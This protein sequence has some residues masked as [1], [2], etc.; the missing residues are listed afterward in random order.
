MLDMLGRG[1]DTPLDDEY[2]IRIFWEEA[3]ENIKDCIPLEKELYTAMM[4]PTMM[5]P[6]P[7]PLIQAEFG[8]KRLEVVTPQSIVHRTQRVVPVLQNYRQ[9]LAILS[10]FSDVC[11][12]SQRRLFTNRKFLFICFLVT[13][14][15]THAQFLKHMP[16]FLNKIDFSWV[17]V[18]SFLIYNFEKGEAYFGTTSSY[19]MQ[20]QSNFSMRAA[21]IEKIEDKPR[22]C[23]CKQGCPQC[24]AITILV[25]NNQIIT[26]WDKNRAYYTEKITEN[27][28]RL[29][30][31]EVSSIGPVLLDLKMAFSNDNNETTTGDS[32]ENSDAKDN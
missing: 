21:S 5:F 25:D 3:I 8:K 24:M 15:M 26:D 4:H 10:S 12:Y 32:A 19:L 9:R 2:T 17:P 28:D 23:G 29:C 14:P 20:N 18:K 13:L 1:G 16:Y 30:T 31:T 6:M 27:F 22:A 7:I 11:A